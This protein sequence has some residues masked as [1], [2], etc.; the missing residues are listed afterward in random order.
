MNTH[1]HI[2]ESYTNLYRIWKDDRL[3]KQLRNLIEVFIKKY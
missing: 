3:R 2:L 1:L